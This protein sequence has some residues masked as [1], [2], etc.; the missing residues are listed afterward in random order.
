MLNPCKSVV[1]IPWKAKTQKDHVTHHSKNKNRL[2]H[3]FSDAE[4]KGK[5]LRNAAQWLSITQSPKGFQKTNLREQ[6][7]CATEKNYLH[8]EKA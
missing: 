7:Y 2:I 6:H 1:G 5:W 8:P 4:K 3:L